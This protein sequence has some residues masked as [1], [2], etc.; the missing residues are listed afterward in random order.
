MS[1]IN[2]NTDFSSLKITNNYPTLVGGTWTAKLVNGVTVY[3]NGTTEYT[4]PVNL[5]GGTLNIQNG[6]IV[7]GLVAVNSPTINVQSGGTLQNSDVLNGSVSVSG[8][9]LSVG[10]SYLST[11][12]SMSSSS[13]SSDDSFYHT[14]TTNTNSGTLIASGQSYSFR[15]SNNPS[16]LTSADNVKIN[17]PHYYSNN[18]TGTA[19]DTITISGD[20]YFG[21]SNVAQ[22]FNTSLFNQNFAFTLSNNNPTYSGGI[23][24]ASVNSAGETVYSATGVAGGP[25]TGTVKNI[26]GPINLVNPGSVT[27]SA[28]AVADGLTVTGNT[29][30]IIYVYGTIQNSFTANMSMYVYDGGVSQNNEY[31]SQITYVQKGGTTKGDL[32]YEPG[33]ALYGTYK[34]TNTVGATLSPLYIS[35]GSGNLYLASGSTFD[36]SYFA[37]ASGTGVG[38]IYPAYATSV[39]CF[40]AGSMINTINGLKAIEDI[41][42]GDQVITYRGGK[43]ENRSV[44]WIGYN[45]VTVNQSLPEDEANYPV[46]ILKNAVAEN[47]PFEDLLV[48]SEHCILLDGQFIPVRMLVNDTTIFYD[49]T[50]TEYTF[51]HVETEHHSIIKANGVLTETYLDTGNRSSFISNHNIVNMVSNKKRWNKDSAAPLVTTR[52]IVEPIYYEL[53][54]RAETLGVKYQ[55]KNIETTTD[56]GLYLLA[57]SG[58]I[59]NVTYC[60]KGRYV[61]KIP[62]Y[63]TNVQIISNVSQANKVIGNFVDDRRQLGVLVGSVTLLEGNQTYSIDKHFTFSNLK[64]WHAQEGQLYRWTSGQAELPIKEKISNTVGMLVINILAGGPY[65]LQKDNFIAKAG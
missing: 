6:A 44:I 59:L 63:V 60:N 32:F 7:D 2:A 29:S 4:G 24:T 13:T 25:A 1:N 27:I 48:T 64:G 16:S 51:Y 47:V 5:V 20:G 12:V 28:G 40:L 61:F 37:R 56:Y 65:I 54:N 46:R 19:T 30:P 22:G 36:G 58:E 62:E 11:T 18:Y 15:T 9:G 49:H 39:A 45:T 3:T 26:K 52:E 38:Y 23:W 8:G 42:V 50:I 55:T 34:L 14:N 41:Q 57:D 33:S 43:Q 35:D 53:I 17:N 21:S 31:I 10:N